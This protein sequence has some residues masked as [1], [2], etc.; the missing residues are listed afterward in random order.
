MEV[1][2]VVK[3]FKLLL[4]MD[5][6]LRGLQVI[7]VGTVHD[8]G[9]PGRHLDAF[10]TGKPGG[11]ALAHAAASLL[12]MKSCFPIYGRHATLSVNVVEPLCA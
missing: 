12:F 3:S 4:P 11:V 5:A 9:N 6:D 1:A 7:R 8:A 2:D 10:P